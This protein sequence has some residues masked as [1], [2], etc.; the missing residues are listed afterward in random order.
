MSKAMMRDLCPH[1]AIITATAL[2][3]AATG[4]GTPRQAGN[5][6]TSLAEGKQRGTPFLGREDYSERLGLVMREALWNHTFLIPWVLVSGSDAS[7][8]FVAERY[9]SEYRFDR[10]YVHVTTDEK[11]TA[12]IT[13]YQ[14][15]GSDWAI[16]GR[17][18]ADFRP[19]AESIAGEIAKKLTDHRGVIR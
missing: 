18:A 3:L 11:V 9:R 17:L 10:I 12:N 15:I 7:L 6:E 4:C 1:F 8:W 16:L 13:P 5:R 14:F 2:I 19:E